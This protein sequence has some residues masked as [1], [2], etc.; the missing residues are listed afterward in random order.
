VCT[1]IQIDEGVQK[2]F[3]K[4]EY[5]RDGDSF[6]SPWSNTYFPAAPD[7]TFFPSSGLLQLEQKANQLFADYVQSYY[8]YALSSVYFVD[9]ETPGF[10]ACFLV[11]KELRN[12]KAIKYG[13]WDAIHVVTCNLKF[14]PKA[15]YR[16]ISTVMISLESSSQMIGDFSMAGS[17]AKTREESVTLPADFGTK[18]DADGFHLA[19][20]GRMIETNEDQLRNEVTENYVNKQRMITNSGRLL[21]EY[22]TGS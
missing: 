10:N 9:T 13:C 5:N 14:A 19:T 3:L 18:V 6:R 8:D 16:V 1:A 2:E 7:C 22:M 11:K 20:V 21:E 4:H 17:C 15:D 12:E